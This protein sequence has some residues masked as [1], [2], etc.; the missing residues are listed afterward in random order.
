MTTARAVGITRPGGPEVLAVVEREVRE[1]GPGEVRIAV[2]AAAVNPTDIGLR[3]RGADELPPPWVPGMDAAGAVESV[4]A[5]VVHVVAGDAVM[6]VVAP[7]RAE[8][9]AQGALVVVPAASVV[10]VPDGMTPAQAATLPMNGLTALQGLALLGL[11]AGQT[12]LVTGGAGLLASYVIPIAKRRALRVLADAAPK[13]EALVS[14]FGA[15]VLLPRGDALVAAVRTEVPEGVDAVFDTAL[16]R[17]A[18]FPAIREGGALAVVR[19]WDGDDVE[20]GI[21]IEKV[22]V[23][24]VLERTDWLEEV[25]ELAGEGVLLPRVAGTYPPEAAGDA[26][27][28]LEAGGLRGRDVIVFGDG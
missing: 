24:T 9:G 25:R 28:R 10:P 1:P 8:G 27:R 19:T 3:Q 20:Q 13:D 21:R 16:L 22:Q 14:S 7:R 5:G 12:L 15:D 18:M 2:G 4:G 26:H 23:W 11:V 6:A 17:R